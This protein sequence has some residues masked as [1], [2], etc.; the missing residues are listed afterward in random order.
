MIDT[1]LALNVYV[2]V[3]CLLLSCLRVIDKLSDYLLLFIKVVKTFV[4]GASHLV[5]MGQRFH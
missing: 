4:L 5:G 3:S 1:L 2:S